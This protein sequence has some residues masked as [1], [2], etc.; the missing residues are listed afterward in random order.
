METRPTKLASRTNWTG[1]R[2]LHIHIASAASAAMEEVAAANF[3]AGPGIEG[4][5]YFL[6]TGTYSASAKPEFREVTFFESEVLEA[7]S[8]NDPPCNPL[9]SSSGRRSTAVTSRSVACL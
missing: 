4:D 7:L 2:L 8:R 1:G 6:G 5:R 3:V 9:P